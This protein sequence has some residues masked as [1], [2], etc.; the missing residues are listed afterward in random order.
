M[1]TSTA[2]RQ[3][4]RVIQLQKK[5]KLR[6][7][8]DCFIAEGMKMALEAPREQIL[9]VYLSESFAREKGLPG[10]LEHLP[11]EV[12]EDRVFEQMSDTITPQGILCLIRQFHYTQEDLLK[13]ENPLLLL[14]EDLQDPG[15]V[16]TIFRTAEGAGVDGIILSHNSVD[17]YNPKTIRSTMGSVYR[18]PFL[19]A[20]DLPEILKILKKEGICTYAAHLDGQNTYDR[21]DYRGGTAFLI[22][23]EGNGLSSELTAGAQRRIKIPME[24]KL[25]SL[26]AAVAA[27]L[28]MYE[29]HRQ[30]S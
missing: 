2:N 30:R 4:K 26:N 24:G 16:G 13:K 19:Y 9:Q 27:A 29:V 15:N 18:M 22:G 11:C 14:L 8:E 23:N 7:E 10:Q 25:E 20:Q 21:E 12:V 28:L 5:G 17:I 1:I 6:R 3:V